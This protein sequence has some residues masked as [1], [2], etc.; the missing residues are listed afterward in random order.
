MK[1][2]INFIKDWALPVGM[3][4]GILVYL[5]FRSIPAL[6]DFGNFFE[7]IAN[8]S[9]PIFLFL[10]LYVTFCK[11]DFHR[12]RFEMW[13][14]WIIIIQTLMI[15]A[16]M[17]VLLFCIDSKSDK[18]LWESILMCVIG[19]TATASAVVSAK[20][21]GDLASITSFTLF[22][23]FVAA[24]EIP[25][26]LPMVETG[27]GLTFI[28]AF[29]II[30]YKVFTVLIVPLF[31]GWATQ[32]Y[33]PRLQKWIANRP[34][35]GFYIW[36]GSLTIVMGTTAKNICNSNSSI[37]LLLMIAA[38]SLISCLLQFGLG[39]LVGIHTDSRINAT[40]AL[41]QKNTSFEIW[42]AFTYLN[43]VS[44]AGPGCYILWQNTLNSIE[45]WRERRI[46]TRSQAIRE[47]FH[48][49]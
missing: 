10:V 28:Q 9:L 38:A 40:Q 48:E 43:P 1:H 33:L 8:E 44:S 14:L 36:A 41:G 23:N 22:S 47:S 42:I 29:L 37:L 4:I 46:L 15:V 35:L 49:K 32:R 25:F 27:E 39:K 31:L 17:A 7:P 11:V 12:M 2:F 19:P 6:D 18:I 20:L 16:I 3:T 34:D 24:L 45:L 26:F 21:G 13:H 30:L 5:I